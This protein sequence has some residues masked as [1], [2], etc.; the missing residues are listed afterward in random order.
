MPPSFSA[1]PMAL[2]STDT[3]PPTG[4]A[5]SATT[6]IE[7]LAPRRSRW[8]IVAATGS[9]SKGIS[10]IRMAWAPDAVPAHRAIHPA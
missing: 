10:G 8:A 4:A 3:S 9:S 6:T 5:P 7:N 2:P 1:C